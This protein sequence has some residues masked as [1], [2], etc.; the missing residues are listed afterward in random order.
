MEANFG[1]FNNTNVQENFALI[2]ELLDEILDFGYLQSTDPDILRILITQQGTVGAAKEDA[3]KI[4]SQV[5]GQI[6][7]RR[8][9]IKYRKHEVFLDVLESVS[10]LMSPNGQPLNAHVSGSIRMK[11][12]LSGMPDCKF[13]INDKVSSTTQDVAKTAAKNSK[14][15]QTLSDPVAIDD[16]TFH[17]CVRLGSFDTSKTISFIPPDGDF[18][19]MKYRTT[20]D[21]ILPF[22]VT[23]H[24]HEL[25]NKISITLD[26]K[27]DF[28][29][30]LEGSKVEVTLPTPNTAA[31]VLVRAE[32]GKAKYKPGSNA[33]I[34]KLQNL[35]GQKGAQMQ[36]DID[37]LSTADKKKWT[38]PPISVYFEVPFACSGLTVKFLKIVET[39]L[40]YEDTTVLKWVRYISRSG[41][42]EIRY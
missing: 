7:W 17:Q 34:W 28:D 42:Y 29:Q 35:Q 39:K 11:C 20:Q 14:K 2:Y 25:G 16:L 1:D 13:G 41:Q 5:T 40:N 15:K 38:R 31:G 22:R 27:A 32:K 10:L 21:V 9:N 24:V 12:H 36:V 6:G 30:K 3:Q 33:V 4:T 23:P 8:E 26:I 18:E 37:M 19:L